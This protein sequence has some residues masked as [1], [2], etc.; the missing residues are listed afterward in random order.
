MLR[1]FHKRK[2]QS[3]LEY[4]VLVMIIIGALVTIQT[5]IK[6]GV[7]GRLKTSSDDIGDQYSPGNTNAVKTTTVH[8]KTQQLYGQDETGNIKQGQSVEKIVE[9][10]VTNTTENSQII[11]VNKEFWGSEP[12]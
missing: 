8:S 9:P 7:Q 1:S 4:A 2:G 10:E 12:H 5:Y 6:R 3:T 11:D